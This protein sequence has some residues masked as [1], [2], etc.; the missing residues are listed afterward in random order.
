MKG[1]TCGVSQ[2]SNLGPT[3]LNDIKMFL[4]YYNLYDKDDTNY[5]TTMVQMY[6]YTHNDLP[7]RED[8]E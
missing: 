5:I 4:M 3:L 8:N 2:G 1:T 6:F 7:T